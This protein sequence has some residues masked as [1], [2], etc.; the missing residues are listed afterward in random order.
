MKNGK[1]K[2]KRNRITVKEEAVHIHTSH[3][4]PFCVVNYF[5]I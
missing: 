5:T 3:C 4:L 1:E 2:R